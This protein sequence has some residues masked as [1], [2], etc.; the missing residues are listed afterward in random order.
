[1]TPNGK[2]DR[3]ALLS[4]QPSGDAEGDYIAP[5]T[6]AE[7]ALASIWE[8]VLE[9]QNISVDADFFQSGGHSLLA[10]GLLSRIRSRLR[11]SVPTR[12]LFESPTIEG[13]AATVT[14]M[15]S[16]STTDQ[17]GPGLTAR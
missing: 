4:H 7:A 14:R 11:V 12:V 6:A 9:K 16:E 5:R 1:M 13:L 17:P 8:E 10:A 2:I 15:T 3:N